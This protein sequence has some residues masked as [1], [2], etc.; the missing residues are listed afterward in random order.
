VNVTKTEAQTNID[1][2]IISKWNITKAFPYNEDTPLILPNHQLF[3][4]QFKL[5]AAE[6]VFYESIAPLL[7][8]EKKLPDT[9]LNLNSFDFSENLD[10]TDGLSSIISQ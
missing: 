7:N 9:F 5:P 8:S 3:G 1:F 2:S 10:T 6:Y 4:I